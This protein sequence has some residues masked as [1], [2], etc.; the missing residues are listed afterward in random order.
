MCLETTKRKE[1]MTNTNATTFQVPML[2]KEIY[3]NWCIW[4]NAL[5]GAY[6]VWEMVESWVDEAEDDSATKKKDQKTLTLIHQ[7]LDEKM[8]EK[9][10]NATTS[11]QAWDILQTFFKDLD[12]VKKVHL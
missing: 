5:L 4:M 1:K 7:S 2:T 10:A 8:F 3:G 12:K 11:K 6:D 9:V